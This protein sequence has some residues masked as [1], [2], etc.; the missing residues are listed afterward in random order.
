M[1]VSMCECDSVTVSVCK[2]VSVCECVVV[3]SV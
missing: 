1:C 3:R 2:I